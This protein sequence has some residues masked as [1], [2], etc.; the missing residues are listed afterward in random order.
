MSARRFDIQVYQIH[1]PA[2]RQ[3]QA[4]FFFPVLCSSFHASLLFQSSAEAGKEGFSDFQKA[5]ICRIGEVSG[6]GGVDG[7]GQW[8]ISLLGQ[9]AKPFAIAQLPVT[10]KADCF[11]Q[12]GMEPG[13]DGVALSRVGC[14][15]IIIETV[16]QEIAT[17]QPLILCKGQEALLQHVSGVALPFHKNRFWLWQND[18]ISHDG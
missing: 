2:L 17:G 1:P 9:P 5:K 15:R 11:Q 3:E 6:K 12:Q 8:R 18:S 7:M 13:G 16:H 10:E 4:Q 14:V